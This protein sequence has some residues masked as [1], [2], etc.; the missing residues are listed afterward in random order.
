MSLLSGVADPG[1]NADARGCKT[2]SNPQAVPDNPTRLHT[3][4]GR[5]PCPRFLYQV[6]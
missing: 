3:P 2:R 5:L 6:L 4:S 1:R